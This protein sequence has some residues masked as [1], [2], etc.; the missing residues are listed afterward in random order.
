ML[1][2]FKEEKIYV[3]KAVDSYIKEQNKMPLGFMISKK[4][5]RKNI[6]KVKKRATDK[7]RF[8]KLMRYR[9][10]IETERKRIDEVVEKINK[11]FNDYLKSIEGTINANVKPFKLEANE[12]EL[13]HSITADTEIVKI[14]CE[15]FQIAF[16][17]EIIGDDK[18]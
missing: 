14:K 6:E 7:Y 18:K 15:P 10:E 17:Q 1:D 13:N 5:L 4:T 9:G 8:D 2:W 12:Y 16:L 11:K 3:E